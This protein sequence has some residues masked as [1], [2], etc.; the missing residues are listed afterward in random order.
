VRRTLLTAGAA[1]LAAA[2][3]P[4]ARAPWTALSMEA[5]E[6]Y[7]GVPGMERSAVEVAATGEGFRTRVVLVR[8]DPARFRFSLTARV[9]DLAPA[10]TIENAPA[11]AALALNAGQFNAFVPWGWLVMGGDEL[12]PPGHGPLSTAITWDAGGHMR[13]LAPGD[14]PAARAAGDVVEAL[15][16]YPTLLDDTGTIPLPLREEGHGVDIHHRDG[17]LALG[18]LDDG[19]LLVAITRFYGIGPLSPSI[20]LGPTLAEM[21]TL[22]RAQGCRRA[23]SLDGGISAQLLVREEGRTR[24]WRGWRKVPLGLIAEPR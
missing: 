6:W 23:V 17:R 5:T 18:Q 13:W 8:M 16:S 19:R 11:S 21:A 4:S 9:T 10:W 1:L 7:S 24:T 14:I 15:Q 12:R 22:M 20:P 2:S 3:V